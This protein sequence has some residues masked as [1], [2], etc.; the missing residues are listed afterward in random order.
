M[1]NYQGDTL[2][3]CTAENCGDIGVSYFAFENSDQG[4]VT[5]FSVHNM[6][7]NLS[8]LYWGWAKRLNKLDENGYALET[9][10][11]DQDDEFVGGNMIPITLNEYDAHG[12]LV[13][14]TNLDKN[15]NIIN[16]PVNGAATTEYKYDEQGN[17]TETLYFD[18]DNKAITP[19]ESFPM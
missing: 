2:Y 19:K 11:Y 3:S 5:S 18:K 17:R 7:G 15:R 1:A 4:D 12:A 13:K 16:H 6:E 14:V 10:V 9:A 8:N